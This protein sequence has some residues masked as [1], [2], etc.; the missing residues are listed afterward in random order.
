MNK[1]LL[2]K[3]VILLIISLIFGTA[4]TVYFGNNMLPGSIL[5]LLCDTLSLVVII[6]G[7]RMIKTSIK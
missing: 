6:I 1:R 7:L 2:I 3:G 4:E 5:E